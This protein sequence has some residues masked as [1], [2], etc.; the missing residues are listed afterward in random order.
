MPV[1]ESTPDFLV[2]M[3]SARTSRANAAVAASRAVV[4]TIVGEGGLQ[5]MVWCGCVVGK[6]QKT[7]DRSQAAATGNKSRASHHE[8]KVN[9]ASWHLSATVR[10]ARCRQDQDAGERL[11]CG[12]DC[13]GPPT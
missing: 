10:L 11:E 8:R 12:V 9:H 4:R 6:R 5:Q 13:R 1:M 7:E 2:Y 3:L